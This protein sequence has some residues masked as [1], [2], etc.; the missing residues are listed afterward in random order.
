MIL[1]LGF[2]GNFV[3]FDGFRF[4]IDGQAYSNFNV[5][6]DRITSFCGEG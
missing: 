3:P 5:F 6:Y 2:Y 1:T 4:E